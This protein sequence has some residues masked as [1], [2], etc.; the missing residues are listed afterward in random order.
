MWMGKKSIRKSYF[1]QHDGGK[2]S[3]RRL[4]AIWPPLPLV[5]YCKT[6]LDSTA[7]SPPYDA[8]VCWGAP[9]IYYAVLLKGKCV[10]TDFKK[11]KPYGRGQR[12]Q[13]GVRPGLQRT[14]VSVHSDTR[15]QSSV[16]CEGVDVSKASCHLCHIFRC[17]CSLLWGTITAELIHHQL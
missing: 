6:K 5:I 3:Y 13:A 16:S 2:A 11:I 1:K 8:G 17:F 14:A 15:K 10:Q 4:R 9:M 12:V 7:C